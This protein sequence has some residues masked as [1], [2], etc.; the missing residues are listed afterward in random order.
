MNL[1]SALTAGFASDIS[2]DQN[3]INLGNQLMYLGVVLLE[4]PS[5]LLLQRVSAATRPSHSYLYLYRLTLISPK[6]DRPAEMDL[7]PGACLWVRRHL[8]SIHHEQDWFLS[9]AG[10]AR[11]D[12]VGIHP[13]GALYVVDL[14]HQRAIGEALGSFLLRHVRWKRYSTYIGLGN[15]K[16][17]WGTGPEGLAVALSE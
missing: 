4:I 3:T 5:N 1:A 14:V 16:A 9:L 17:G 7:G 13:R 15:P 10:R 11:V 8:P 2:V 6:S 12:G